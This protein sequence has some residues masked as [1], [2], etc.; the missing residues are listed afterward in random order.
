MRLLKGK[1]VL[2]TAPTPK[3]ASNDYL[4]TTQPFELPKAMGIN[5]LSPVFLTWNKMTGDQGSVL[6]RDSWLVTYCEI[7]DTLLHLSYL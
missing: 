3:L 5:P 1:Q 7:L 2:K 4:D 6:E